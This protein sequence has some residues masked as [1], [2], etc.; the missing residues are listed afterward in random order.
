MKKLFSIVCPVIYLIILFFIKFFIYF[1]LIKAFNNG[2]HVGVTTLMLLFS[3][4]Y[5][6]FGTHFIIKIVLIG[7]VYE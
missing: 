6:I 2:N 5:I 7:N 3:F 4:I 1:K